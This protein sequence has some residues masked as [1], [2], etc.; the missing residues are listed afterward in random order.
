MIYRSL[1][2]LQLI[3]LSLM[4]TRAFE[5]MT[6]FLYSFIDCYE[7]ISGSYCYKHS[8]WWRLGAVEYRRSSSADCLILSFTP[9]H[10]L[11]PLSCFIS[12]LSSM[13]TWYF[14]VFYYYY[15]YFGLWGYKS[16][17]NRDTALFHSLLCH[18]GLNNVWHLIDTQ[19]VLVEWTPHNHHQSRNTS[20]DA[21]NWS[22]WMLFNHSVL[23][24]LQSHALFET[25]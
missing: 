8:S 3:I 7:I 1:P 18:Q 16:Y 15:Y 9:S 10:G 25:Y 23:Q 14:M 2:S 12:L 5:S 24:F 21:I 11:R 17:E 20:P 19:W 6:S 4:W 13:S 22:S